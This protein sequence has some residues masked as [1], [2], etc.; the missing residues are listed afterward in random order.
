M[1][2][3]SISTRRD[4]IS[5]LRNKNYLM[6]PANGFS[7]SPALTEVRQH[8]WSDWDDLKPDNYLKNNSRFRTRRFANF[9]FL[10]STQEVR[11]L[12]HKAYFQESKLNSYAGGIH[13]ELAPLKKA[14]LIN[15]FLHELIKFNFRHFP[16]DDGM[17]EQSWN[18]DV[19][20]IRIVATPG[21]EGEPTPEGAHHDE[22]D[23][24]CMHL[25]NCQNTLGGVSTIYDTN[26]KPLESFT[27]HDPMDSVIVWDPHVMHGVSPICPRDLD[28]RAVRD[29]LLM[30]YSH[31]PDLEI[32]AAA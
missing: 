32:P 23:F 14:T 21:E 8:L 31:V 16:V 6:I 29:M 19:H 24:V 9:Y 15:P 22:N 30:G 12:P 2:I 1:S 7:I 27:L 25:I 28:K 11:P 17:A 4:I 10:P 26:R 13:R 5:E 18:V 20:Q 3:E